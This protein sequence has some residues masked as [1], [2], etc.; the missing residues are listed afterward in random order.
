MPKLN[1]T[2]SL[3]TLG[4]I[5]HGKS[6]SLGRFFY[7]IG[8]VD[9]RE[10]AKLEAESKE[11]KRSSWK[12]AFI[13]DSTEEE[14]QG[15]ITADIAFQP[16]STDED[17]NFMLIDA[18]G[19][20]DY[21]RNAIRGA[22][23][24]DACLLVL[25]AEKGDLS[26]GLKKSTSKDQYQG[27]TREHA[28]IGTVLGIKQVKFIINKMDL[29]GFKEE[30]YL[31]A[32]DAIKQL[33]KEIQ[34]PWLKQLTKT[35][36][37]PISGLQGENLVNPSTNMPWYEGPTL[38]Q[39]LNEF[40]PHVISTDKQ[41]FLVHDAFEMQGI[42]TVLHGRLISGKLHADQKAVVLPSNN[43]GEIKEV[44][45]V[46]TEPLHELNAGGYGILHLRN[47]ERENLY[48][49]IIVADP[50]DYPVAPNLIEV[51][52]LILEN[53]GKPLIPGS[54]IIL[55]VG[56]NHTAA[57]IERIINVEKEKKPRKSGKRIMMAFPGELVVIELKPELPIIVEKYSEQPILGRAVMRSMGQTIAV[58]IIINYN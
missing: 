20:R 47:I 35:S 28:I 45:D 58:G 17:H 5:D 18:P 25:S 37:I 30:A 52:V 21:V 9:S 8:A 4:H 29:V 55:H 26:S 10:M 2:I 1:Q 22:A 12:W 51:R 49:G 14:R 43:V 57:R 46:N 24:A 38:V 7:E 42:G 50:T 44:W 56:L 40:K 41:R 53:A 34:S 6:T 19:H 36:F 11:L 16:F 13:L 15:G 33:L 39:A 48:P 27:Q 32:I 54:S 23:L 3:I 31:K